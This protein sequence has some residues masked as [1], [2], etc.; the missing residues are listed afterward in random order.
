MPSETPRCLP[1]VQPTKGHQHK[2][3]SCPLPK[4]EFPRTSM[5]ELDLQAFAGPVVWVPSSSTTC[6]DASS[7][8]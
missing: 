4:Y 3:R 5:V 1:Y 6:L 2:L 7:I 8:V